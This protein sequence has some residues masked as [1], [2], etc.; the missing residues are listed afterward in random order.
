MKKSGFIL[1]FLAPAML[2]AIGTPPACLGNAPV[3]SFRLLVESAK[4]GPAIPVN[5]IN[6]ILPGEKLK[7]E[8]V[9]LPAP[10][11][12]KARI[13]IVLVPTSGAGQ[14]DMQV[15]E[16]H[17]AKL[18][19][20]WN[21]TLRASVLG[22]VFGPRGLNVKTVSNLVKKNPDLIPQLADYAQ[23]TTTVQALVE[24]LSQVEESPT[25]G[26]NM[27]A[28]LSGF[29]N[30]FGVSLPKLD[31]T[32]PTRQQAA[33]LLGAIL[34]SLS[35]YD[36]LTD[37]RTKL[38]QQSTSLAASVAGLFL[39]TPLGLA[40]G[41][42]ALI[43]SFRA[44][45]FPDTYFR[46]AFAQTTAGNGVSLC[47]QKTPIKSRTRIAYLWMLRVPDA[48]AP[49]LDL[50][51]AVSLPIGGKVSIQVTSPRPTQLRTLPRAHNWR[52]VSATQH[53]SVPTKV[54]VGP[55][56]ATLKL[57]LTQ[58]KLPPGEYRLAGDW[59]W[60]PFEAQGTLALRPYATFEAVKLAPGKGDQLIAGNGPREVKLTGSDFEFV[61]KVALS[62]MGSSA[63]PPQEL[64][65]SLGK[66]KAGV[67]DSS[68]TTTIDTSSL[69]PGGYWLAL[70]QSNGQAQNVPVTVHPPNPKIDNLP[71]RVNLGEASQTVELRGSGLE[72]ID[73]IT[74]SQATWQLEPV[75]PNSAEEKARKVTIKLGAQAQKG[76]RLDASLFVE[77]IQQPLPLSDAIEVLG[78][79]PKILSA[80]ASFPEAGDVALRASELP[81]D[82]PVSF[83][84]STANV[85]TRPQLELACRNS[86]EAKQA[87][88]LV[89]GDRNG[90]AELD[91]ESGGGLFLSLEPGAVGRS[92][93]LLTAVVTA[94]DAGTSAPVTLGRIIR[95]PHISKF[96]LTDRRVGPSLFAGTL[97]GEGL[98]MI[99]KTGWNPKTG[100]PVQGIPTPVPGNPQEQT[101]DVQLTWPAPLPHAPLYVWLHGETQG[102]LTK[103]R[104]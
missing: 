65:F 100:F 82:S 102:R 85:T 80:Q 86:S 89:P 97:A 76:E 19:A 84:I 31:A 24:R 77:G 20:E 99:D 90:T 10:I 27:N 93:C 4:G 92:G 23:Q 39:G 67:G 94:E 72:R 7:Y 57:D 16:A 68:L 58:L 71:V 13:A 30:E 44:M 47:A 18:P 49:S 91:F 95:L 28:A 98:Q 43:Q 79:R 50:P 70:T 34:P 48:E 46:S 83:V 54:T 40:A 74:S 29:S 12:E 41:G 53:A 2:G 88:T 42:A 60:T 61:Q 103:V 38:V 9:S 8:P 5:R 59:D 52:L 1:A 51:K 81:A 62:R 55:S 15:L 73:H 66:E 6:M 87:L 101:L 63:R 37:Q 26:Q 96:E 25:P 35:T 11:K 69:V 64:A 3:G 17:P 21:V 75:S 32:A 33:Q 36:P 78:F 45:A 22:V 104:D 56:D 14:K